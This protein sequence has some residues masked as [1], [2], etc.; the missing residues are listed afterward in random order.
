M[1]DIIKQL[2]LVLQ[3]RRNADPA[4]SYVASL[5]KAG[6]NKI[7]EKVGEEAT[8]TIIAAKDATVSTDVEEV[9]KETA[10]LWFHTLVMLDHLDINPDRIM[11]ELE[12]RFGTSGILE[13][14]SRNN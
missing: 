14:E 2:Y 8:E 6:L 1:S 4:E 9:I 13:K 10:D 7:L 5:H 12:S 11:A 3:D